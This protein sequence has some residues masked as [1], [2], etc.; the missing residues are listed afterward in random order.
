MGC[1]SVSSRTTRSSPSIRSTTA[2][3]VEAAGAAGIPKDDD[4]YKRALI[5]LQRNQNNSEA[6]DHVHKAAGQGQPVTQ[7]IAISV[8]SDMVSCSI[9]GSV[10]ASY[11]KSEVVGA[12]K[13]TSTDG[14]Y[15]IRFGHNTE[16]TVS[17]LTVTRQ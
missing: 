15:G 1:T 2:W 6:N 4:F 5:F 10:V 11:P 17:G 13:L 14:V 8:T 3:A 12:G 16:G 9:N 7:E